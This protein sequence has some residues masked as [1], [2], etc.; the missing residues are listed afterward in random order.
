MRK[1]VRGP[2]DNVEEFTRFIAGVGG[3]A[4]KATISRNHGAET[5][6]RQA[7]SSINPA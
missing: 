6:S 1:A 2:T 4:G 7:R 5:E 3:A